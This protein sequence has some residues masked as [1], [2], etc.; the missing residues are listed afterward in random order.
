[1]SRILTEEEIQEV[2]EDEPIDIVCPF[3]QQRGYRVLLGNKILM[4]GEVRQEDYE[5]WL[6]CPRCYEVI[7]IHG[8][9]KEETVADKIEIVES[10]FDNKF[11][12]ETVNKKRTSVTGRKLTRGKKRMKAVLHEDTD[13][14]LEMRQHGDRVNVPFDS[15]P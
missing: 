9:L 12:V 7:P 1:M 8:G 3:C 6:E 14:D 10:P 4:P 11:I 5:N 15:N 13:I 2:Y